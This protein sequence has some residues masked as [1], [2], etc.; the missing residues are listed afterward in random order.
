[1]NIA[2]CKIC[3]TKLTSSKNF[4]DK[5]FST[6]L[7]VENIFIKCQVIVIRN[8]INLIINEKLIVR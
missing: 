4:S 7:I 5:H 6:V 8:T 3:D 2:N 1:M